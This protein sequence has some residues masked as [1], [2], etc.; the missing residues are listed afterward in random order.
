QAQGLLS[1]GDVVGAERKFVEIADTVRKIREQADVVEARAIFEA[2]K[3]AEERIDWRAAKAYYARAARLQPSNGRTPIVSNRAIIIPETK[4]TNYRPVIR[5]R[6]VS[7]ST[8]CRFARAVIASLIAPRFF[9]R[10]AIIFFFSR[11]NSSLYGLPNREGGCL[12]RPLR[13]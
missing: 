5:L 3:L 7:N 11:S 9:P 2:G 4:S 13:G 8:R 10:V 12:R 1:R 6:I